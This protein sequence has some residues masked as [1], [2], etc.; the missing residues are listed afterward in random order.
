[1]IYKI[2]KDQIERVMKSVLDTMDIK[3][4]I[5]YRSHSLH[6]NDITAT[7][8]LYKDDQVFGYR[9]GYDFIFKYDKRFDSLGFDGHFPKIEKLDFFKMIPE[10][11]VIKYF[12]DKT[13]EYLRGFLDRGNVPEFKRI[14]TEETNTN[15]TNA[16]LQKKL[17]KSLLDSA[18]F[19]GVCG[20]NFN[21]DWDNDRVSGVILKFSSQWY[22]SD[23]DKDALNTKLI[24][25]QRTKLIVKEMVSKYL[26]IENLY[27]GSYLEDC[28][29]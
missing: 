11:V 24:T 22:R 2:S 29:L 15:S 5:M 7:V 17:I 19:E 16:Q 14:M 21:I 12:T 18:S 28:E 10:K 9:F 13:E 26:N 27:V 1:M 4:D 8:Y 23:D 6:T 3:V 20:Y 25:I